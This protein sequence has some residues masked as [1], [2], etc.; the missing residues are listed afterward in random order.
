MLI[1][2]TTRVH[3]FHISNRKETQRRWANFVYLANSSFT[4]PNLHCDA[5]VIMHLQAATKGNVVKVVIQLRLQDR[6]SRFKFVQVT[7]KVSPINM[8]IYW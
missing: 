6:T 7:F 8:C 4:A 1:Y 3:K 2:V 5:D